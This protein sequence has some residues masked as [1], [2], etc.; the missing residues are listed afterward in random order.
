MDERKTASWSGEEERRG[1]EREERSERQRK[2]KA[3]RLEMRLWLCHNCRSALRVVPA[4]RLS[5]FFPTP[6]TCSGGIS[7]HTPYTN[8]VASALP[9]NQANW[10]NAVR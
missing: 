1:E 4:T 9:A 8:D 5:L 2:D 6:S 7:A 3:G 10:L